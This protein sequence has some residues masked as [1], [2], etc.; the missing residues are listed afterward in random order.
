MAEPRSLGRPLLAP[1][2]P[3]AQ[4]QGWRRRGPHYLPTDESAPSR[5]CRDV[6]RASLRVWT[7]SPK[8]FE[9]TG[10]HE[11]L[12]LETQSIGPT[13]KAQLLWQEKSKWG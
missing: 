5:T 11:P 2:P 12:I 1:P 3:L 4:V 6:P 7:A 13:N 9:G 8:S 10:G